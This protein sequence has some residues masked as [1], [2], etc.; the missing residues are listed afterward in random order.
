MVRGVSFVKMKFYCFA[1]PTSY[2]SIPRAV[3]E[4]ASKENLC[5]N[6]YSLKNLLTWPLE[7][8][9]NLF[10]AM[11]MVGRWG[12]ERR[13]RNGENALEFPFN[14]LSNIYPSIFFIAVHNYIS[15]LTRQDEEGNST[16][17]IEMNSFECSKVDFNLE[18]QQI[19]GV[20]SWTRARNGVDRVWEH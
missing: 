10:D 1:P 2:Y 12:W 8:K 7:I 14:T 17:I 16:V 9:I 15:W 13:G 19:F 20:C 6:F 5:S 11:A 4:S 18:L 3:I